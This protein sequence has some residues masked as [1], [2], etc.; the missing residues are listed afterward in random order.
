MRWS[1]TADTLCPI[2]RALALLGDRWTLLVLREFF[3]GARRF[4]EI[5]TTTGISSALLAARL[6]R[7]TA[8]GILER[9]PYQARPRRE[10]YRLT[11]K[12]RDLYPVLIALKGWSERWEASEDEP[13]LVITHRPCG[14]EPSP[15]LVCAACD[16]DIDPRD[17]AVT[18]S[19]AFKNER[20]AA[21]KPSPEC[22]RNGS[23]SGPG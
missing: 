16:A 9:R 13:A 21:A 19:E 18:L 12:G 11:A 10:E 14:C 5:A 2:A 22:E 17:C 6:K 23:R 20:A 7:L 8:G 4:D 15:R 1:A 3:L